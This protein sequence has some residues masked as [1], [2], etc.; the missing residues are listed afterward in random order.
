LISLTNFSSFYLD[1]TGALVTTEGRVAGTQFSIEFLPK[2]ESDN[3]DGNNND[4]G[5]SNSTFTTISR[6][7]SSLGFVLSGDGDDHGPM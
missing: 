1:N 6:I 4:N 7:G 3:N 5:N 2:E